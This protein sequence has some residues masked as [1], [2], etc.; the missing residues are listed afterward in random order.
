M[1]NDKLIRTK[2]FLVK[3]GGDFF[4]TSNFVDNLRGVKNSCGFTNGGN[5]FLLTRCDN[6][7]AK[8]L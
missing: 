5:F 3:I 2:N 6:I 4:S 8:F 1:N 7:D